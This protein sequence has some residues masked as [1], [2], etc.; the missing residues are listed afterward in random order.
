[1]MA[2]R[3]GPASREP[4]S[5]DCLLVCVYFACLPFTAVSTPFGSLLKVI[6]C[7]IA[8]LL[9]LRLLSG[10]VCA[11]LNCVHLFYGL[12]VL[13]AVLSLPLYHPPRSVTTARDLV[14][15][16]LMLLLVSMPIFNRRE[17]EWIETAWLM[18]GAA[19]VFFAL[20][21]GEALSPWEGR[22]VIRILGFPMDQNYFCATLIMASLVSA[23]RLLARRRGSPAY[24]ALLLLIL[25]AILKT[26]SRGGLMGV[27]CGL[28]A[29]ALF[30]VKGLRPRLA[31]LGAGLVLIAAAAYVLLPALPEDVQAR[32][33][34][35]SIAAT[36]GAGRFAIWRRLL[37]YTLRSPGRTA[38]GAGLL[39]SYDT[40]RRA[41][42]SA[43]SA[44][45]TLIQIFCDQGAAGTLLFLLLIAACSLRT[46]RRQPLAFCALLAILAFSMSLSF[47]EFKPYV[48]IL[49]MCA[50]TFAPAPPEGARTN[51]DQGGRN[52]G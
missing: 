24:L 30:G 45:N 2:L 29:Y 19:G 44:H 51:P 37:E 21:T 22:A 4:V 39:S 11:A 40:L 7:P 15:G 6:A 41:G 33:T 52:H 16:L 27:T 36:G 47:Y 14:F 38:W 34:L 8:A 18:A 20:R 48:N 1:M 43:G 49:M 25:F 46:A 28:L 26:G 35:A 23:K 31:A 32:Y 50:M 42:F 5:L 12:H 17:Q 10:R 13:Y 9:G 3:S